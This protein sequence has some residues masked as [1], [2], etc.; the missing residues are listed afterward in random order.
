M[1]MP[2]HRTTTSNYVSVISL[3][4]NTLYVGGRPSTRLFRFKGSIGNL[5]V[6]TAPL[7]GDVIATLHQQAFT[8]AD[9]STISLTNTVRYCYR[10]QSSFTDCYMNTFED[11]NFRLMTILFQLLMSGYR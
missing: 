9:I 7:S 4:F 3:Q 8:G 10:Y 1:Y 11:N 6:S 2:I 5:F